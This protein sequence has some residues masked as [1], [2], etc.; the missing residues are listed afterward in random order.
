M[1]LKY[2]I[3]ATAIV[4][5]GA[6]SGCGTTMSESGETTTQGQNQS[7]ADIDSK[8]DA[9]LTQLYAENALARTLA[10]QAVGILVFPSVFKAGLIAGGAYG[11]GVLRTGGQSVAYYSTA[12]A[13]IGLQAGAEARSEVIMFLDQQ[14]LDDFRAAQGWEAGVNGNVTVIGGRAAGAGSLDTSTIKDPIV[15]FIFGQEGLMAG[16][17]FQGS[18]YTKLD[19]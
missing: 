8:A 4:L 15:G 17:T 16:V 1:S 19:L 2:L 14:A 12:A 9:A 18:K 6:L 7:A 11:E 10:D 3:A 5:S 13:S